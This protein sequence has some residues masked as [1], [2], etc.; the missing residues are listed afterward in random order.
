M[1]SS[2]KTKGN[3][4]ERELCKLLSGIFGGS[5]QRVPNSGAMVGG[6]NSDRR[7]TLSKA[8]DR[9]F[10]GDIIPPDHM[11]R[12]VIES[13]FYA[14]FRW[15]Q[16]LSSCP[17]LDQWIAQTVAVAD[18]DDFWMVAFKIN[19]QGWFVAVSSEA[20]AECS[21][22]NHAEYHSRFG[23]V[24]VADLRGFLEANREAIERLC[25]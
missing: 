3:T 23:R 9:A 11:S 1:P 12:L 20:C 2:S 16:L 6:S 4:A 13:K 22:G 25:G 18:P 14:D 15:H 7:S 24:L 10:R 17:I 21:V 5:F 8:Q 19:R